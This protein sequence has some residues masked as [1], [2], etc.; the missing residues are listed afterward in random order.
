MVNEKKTNTIENNFP[1]VVA[2]LG[3]VD[4]GKTSL[5]DAVRKTNVVSREHGGITQRI[6]AS[7]VE[8]VHEGKSR[9]ITFIDTPGH[10][11]FS[12][13]RGRGAQAADIG[14]LVV[15][16]VDGVMPQTKESISLLKESQIPFIVVF[17][18]VDDP[19]KLVDKA[20]DQLLKE[21]VMLEG[22]G[23]NV[24]FIEVSA[25]TGLNVKEL[26]DLILLVYDLKKAEIS[27]SSEGELKAIVIESKLDQK[28]GPLASVVIKNGTLRLKDELFS[29]EGKLGRVRNLVSAE[30]GNAKE[31]TVGEAVEILGF[32]KIPSV[33]S[34]ITAVPLQEVEKEAQLN[35]DLPTSPFERQ[36]D[37]SIP[38]V[39]AADT[40]GS[41]EAI[42]YSLPEK[43][44]L[45]KEKTGDIEVSDILYAK[46]TGA[47]VLGFNVKTKPEI[48]NLARTEKV[49]VKGYSIIYE[50][51][52]EVNEFV[53]GKLEALQEEI[54]GIAKILASFPYEKTKVLGIKV[55]EGRIAR[56][57][58]LRLLRND[59]VVGESQVSSLRQGKEQ[60]S[61]IEEGQ[62]GGIILSPFLDFQVGDMILSH[63]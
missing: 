15:S 12:K 5:L 33:G 57:D 59:E 36:A 37:D 10:E 22:Y 43:A 28:K 7:S 46:S 1:P 2:V 4:H 48:Q 63:N 6:G 52:D 11:A 40:Q 58:K 35:E 42:K 55:S 25:K 61:K 24:P 19:N 39:L 51:I 17:T 38:I 49:L 41:L 44:K 47:I 8:I 21:D 27:S 34:T 32:D 53:Q 31:A 50:L 20:K 62:E 29:E 56:N 13:M 54:L 16:S 30:G 26:L 60:V 45:V 9:K 3:H 14:V 18:K 23:G